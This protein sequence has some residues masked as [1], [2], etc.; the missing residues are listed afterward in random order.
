MDILKNKCITDVS[1]FQAIGIY[2]GVKKS[3]KKDLCIIYSK[4]K[5]VA[6]AT[7]TTNKVKAAP[8]LVNIDNIK[9]KN[10]Q[11]IVVNSGIANACTGKQGL[12]NAKLMVEETA[13]GLKLKNDEVLVGSTGI[14]GKQLP[15]DKI[16]N[17]INIA[18]NK[19][20][21]E[22]G[23]S[24]SE[25]L[26]TTDSFVKKITVKIE[27]DNKPVLI[28]G[29]AKGSG[30]IHPN[31]A[32]MLGFVVTNANITKKLLSKAL[33]SSVDD[34]YNMISIDGDTSTND[35]VVAMANGTAKNKL[36]DSTSQDYRKFK[37]ALDFVNKELAKMI[38]SDGKHSTKLIEVL[39]KNAKTSTDAKL[40][41]KSV[42]SSNLVKSSFF[43]KG[44]NWGRIMCSLGYSTGN[45]AP[46]KVD[47]FIQNSIGKIQVVKN[48]VGLN[49]CNKKADSILN[50][51]YVNIIIDLK[52]G[53]HNAI[54]WGCNLCYDYVKGKFMIS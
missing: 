47:I 40:C 13:K 8:L 25:A 3:E 12:E 37:N 44:V 52:D 11:A 24:A 21:D 32:T 31:M 28:S 7:F 42:I 51:N 45:F 43:D 17:G 46:D 39:L 38:A 5:A 22:G 26:M 29:T 4:D 19:L 49:F 36:I 48:G 35:M 54:S 10:T 23:I 6:A 1:G 16:I 18:C 50:N 27:L 41:A 15:I 9:S 20:S 33:K 34:S 14:I 2:S 53:N 30:M